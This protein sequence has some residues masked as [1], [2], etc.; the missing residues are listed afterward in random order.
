MERLGKMEAVKHPGWFI[1]VPL[2]DSISYQVDMRERAIDIV[3]QA[4]IT[5]DNVSVDVSGNVYVQFVDPVK[6]AY[7]AKNPLYAVRQ[8]AQSAMRAAIGEMEV[9]EKT[10]NT[11]RHLSP[12]ERTGGRTVY[13]FI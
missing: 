2:V 3:P 11:P 10:N 7:G 1:A 4:A 9:R 13:Q 5:K 8:H 12:W 6:A